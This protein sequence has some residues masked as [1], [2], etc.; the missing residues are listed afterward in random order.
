MKREPKRSA[1]LSPASAN[2]DGAGV[3]QKGMKKI[4]LIIFV[5][6]FP[7]SRLCITELL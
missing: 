2:K 7:E 6:F 5:G 4:T 3:F 1:H